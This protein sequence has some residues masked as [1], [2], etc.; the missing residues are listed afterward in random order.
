MLLYCIF[1]FFF[2]NYFKVVNVNQ[3]KLVLYSR[4]YLI[5]KKANYYQNN[6][7]EKLVD[8]LQRQKNNVKD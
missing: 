8:N 1:K 4:H 7:E 5:G 2:R 6:P 3:K